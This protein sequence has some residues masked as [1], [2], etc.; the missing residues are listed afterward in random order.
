MSY[1]V[2]LLYS[3]PKPESN[4]IDILVGGDAASEYL[5][6]YHEWRTTYGL[7]DSC[8]NELRL[9]ILA[10]SDRDSLSVQQRDRLEWLARMIRR[11]QDSAIAI[12]LQ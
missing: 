2:A 3:S 10:E 6:T 4:R 9:A 5:R 11:E 1:G 12:K 7:Q 8:I